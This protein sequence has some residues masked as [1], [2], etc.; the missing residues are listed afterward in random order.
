MKNK[1]RNLNPYESGEYII[2]NPTLHEEDSAWKVKK[3]TPFLDVVFHGL[4]KSDISLLDV[5]GGVGIILREVGD[6]L[7]K[8]YKMQVKKYCLDLSPDILRIQKKYN[9]DA[10]GFFREDISNT[11]FP[12]KSIDLVLMVDV[13]EH[14][15]EPSRAIS[16]IKRIA[17]YVIFKV[18]L[19]DNLTLK[20]INF[21]T[22]GKFRQEKTFGVLGHVNCYNANSLKKEIEKGGG[23][24][25]MFG[26]ANVFEYLLESPYYQNKNTFIHRVV[27]FLGKTVFLISPHMAA[28]V[29]N[30]FA[31]CLVR[32]D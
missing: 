6:M 25:I 5:G 2:N 12:D 13:L 11:S 16:E 15:P 23:K 26:Y 31:I 28:R 20:T 7:T 27:Y 32:F 18:P 4:N 17:Y 21:F 9:P 19:E 10:V 30:D 24:I 14:I 29:F 22:K 1:S 3:I 8:K